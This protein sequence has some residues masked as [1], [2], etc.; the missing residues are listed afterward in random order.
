MRTAAGRPHIFIPLYM[1]CTL[2]FPSTNIRLE[3]QSLVEEGGGGVGGGG[4]GGAGPPGA[5]LPPLRITIPMD[6]DG[7]SPAPSP[8]APTSLLRNC[9]KDSNSECG[10][11]GLCLAIPSGPHRFTIY[12]SLI[13]AVR[14]RN[15]PDT[16][17]LSCQPVKMSPSYSFF[18]LYL[19]AARPLSFLCREA[20][21]VRHN[22]TKCSVIQKRERRAPLPLDYGDVR[23]STA[24]TISAANSCPTSPRGAGGGSAA[25]NRR[26]ADL[27]LVAQYA[28]LAD[29]RAT[30][31][32][33]SCAHP[34]G[35]HLGF[36][37]YIL[38]KTDILPR[39]TPSSLHHTGFPLYRGLL[40]LFFG[41]VPST[42]ALELTI[43]PGSISAYIGGGVLPPSPYGRR[44]PSAGDQL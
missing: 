43:P 17:F 3:F 7:R 11:P 1:R 18:A 42:A 25:A 9:A 27:G 2:R 14:V 8:T 24:G 41:V 40:P 29:Q 5:P 12:D 16:G 44:A 22:L 39:E 19:H 37:L 21:T 4:G 13:P 31:N 10:A 38:W 30:P 20:F 6:G 35:T 34:I 15:L 32:G 28:A 26:H 33:S 23:V 36:F